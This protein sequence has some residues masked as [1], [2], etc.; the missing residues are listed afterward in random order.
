MGKAL[1]PEAVIVLRTTKT[2]EYQKNSRKEQATV[3]ACF[4]FTA[5][6]LSLGGDKIIRHVP[7]H[8][9]RGTPG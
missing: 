9:G 1:V 4:A 3:V 6:D 5:Q 8:R 7:Y 2:T